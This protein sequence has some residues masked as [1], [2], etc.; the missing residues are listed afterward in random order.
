MKK[1][2]LF[3]FFIVIIIGLIVLNLIKC[4]KKIKVNKY[5][6][7]KLINGI[8]SYEDPNIYFNLKNT[9]KFIE[10]NIWNKLIF[11][12]NNSD[13][14]IISNGDFQFL[15]DGNYLIDINGNLFDFRDNQKYNKLLLSV[16]IGIF[17]NDIMIDSKWSNSD[18]YGRCIFNIS[19]KYEITTKDILSIKFIFNDNIDDFIQVNNIPNTDI[20]KYKYNY[21]NGIEN[22]NIKI[23]N[24][25]LIN[26]QNNYLLDKLNN[27]NNLNNKLDNLL[28]KNDNQIP[29]INNQINDISNQIK[30]ISNQIKDINNKIK[31]INN[32]MNI[33]QPIID[34]K[35]PADILYKLDDYSG[36]YNLTNNLIRYTKPISNNGNDFIKTNN[37]GKFLLKKGFSYKITYNIAFDIIKKSL[38]AKTGVITTKYNDYRIDIYDENKNDFFIYSDKNIS[39]INT[40][41]GDDPTKNIICN[42]DL[43]KYEKD[44][45][46]FS[47]KIKNSSL[48][49]NYILK[50]TSDLLKKAVFYN[51]ISITKIIN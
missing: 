43:S 42:I 23:T 19:N 41:T 14:I 30:D 4:K 40:I 8:E 11:N 15:N 3:I 21:K 22:I 46:I 5:E 35:L 18:Y 29:N 51:K 33:N 39:N 44:Y 10:N 38:N 50:D 37:D 32:Q 9:P 34:I 1:I 6:N 27:L 48:D 47:I 2:D 13:Y 31:D 25:D 49:D 20:N 16:G 12:N 45:F 36:P 17:K 24:L 28:K 26:K 7:F